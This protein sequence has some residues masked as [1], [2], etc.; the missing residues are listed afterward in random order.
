MRITLIFIFVSLLLTG[1]EQTVNHWREGDEQVPS[2]KDFTVSVAPSVSAV[3]LKLTSHQGL[4]DASLR[5]LNALL[6][7]QGRI[8][9]QS[10]LVQPY[11]KNGERFAARLRSSLMNAG[12]E[13]VRIQSRT[14]SAEKPAW[15]LK[16]QSQALVVSV[17]DCRIKTPGQWM[18]KPYEAIG[19]LGCANRANLA[20]MVADPQDLIR[21]KPLDPGD[22]VAAVNAVKRYQED[23]LKALLDIDFN[24]D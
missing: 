2:G 24:D 21:A 6:N 20:R 3:S 18:T 22:G 16:V 11:T 12:A 15:D 8:G 10:I 19:P 1:C 23:D 13:Q 14:F 5:D 7:N 9:S 4:N 17:P